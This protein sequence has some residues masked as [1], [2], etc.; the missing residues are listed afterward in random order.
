MIGVSIVG[1]KLR[2]WQ[3]ALKCSDDSGVLLK[4][5]VISESKKRYS[6]EIGEYVFAD[7]SNLLRQ[8]EGILR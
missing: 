5:A 7:E 4:Y 1:L 6:A 8:L 2:R 3:L